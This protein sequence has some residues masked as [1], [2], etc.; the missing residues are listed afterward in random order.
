MQLVHRKAIR[1][2]E[3]LFSALG[4]IKRDAALE[5]GCGDCLVSKDFLRRY[6]AHIDLLD[7]CEEAG[8]EMRSFQR[9]CKKVRHL[10]LT[11]MQNFSTP[12]RYNCIVL[13]Y[14]I[15][16]LEDDD[17]ATFLKKLGGMLGSEKE[18]TRAAASSSIILIQDQVIPEDRPEFWEHNQKVRRW[19]SFDRIIKTAGLSIVRKSALEQLDSK[20]WPVFAMALAP[21][22]G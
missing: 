21:P 6:F 4:M 18:N 1:Q 19:S 8:K 20:V 2:M 13:R 7:Q 12:L 16:Y 14:S 17:A 15:G 22:S 3:G 9:S 11:P 5:I 10:F